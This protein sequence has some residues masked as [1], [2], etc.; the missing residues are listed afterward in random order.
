MLKRLFARLIGL[1]L[2]GKLQLA[3]GLAML[4]AAAFIAW[5]FHK[6][7]ADRDALLDFASTSCAA[8]GAEFAA[9]SVEQLDG[10]GR[11]RVVK[12]KRGEACSSRIREL[13]K[14]E[15]DALEASNKALAA[16]LVEHNRKSEADAGAA[17]RDNAA[18][19]AAARKME[20]AENAVSSD[21]R[22]SGDWFDAF[23][24]LAGLRAAE[25]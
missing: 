16:A 8:T 9:S 2:A 4:A 19:I 3:A 11:A 25:R 1:P 17:A 14:F 20:R 13:V 6:L 18:A 22:V 5:Q 12:L 7:A 10:K 24:G 15:H 23:N 21:N